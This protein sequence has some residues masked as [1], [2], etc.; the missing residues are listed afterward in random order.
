[1]TGYISSSEDKFIETLNEKSKRMFININVSIKVHI[2]EKDDLAIT[3]QFPNREEGGFCIGKYSD[4][5][6]ITGSWFKK[7]YSASLSEM[8]EHM[9]DY[10]LDCISDTITL[11]PVGMKL[12]EF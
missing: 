12:L 4:T 7:D 2:F 1:M 11:M 6:Y 9:R 3:F 5:Y 10:L 8:R